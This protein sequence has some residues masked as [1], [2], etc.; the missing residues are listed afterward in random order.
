MVCQNS[1]H[2]VFLADISEDDAEP[3]DGN[4]T[5]MNFFYIRQFQVCLYR[6]FLYLV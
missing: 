6:K 3:D 1:S 5:E 2:F 4:A